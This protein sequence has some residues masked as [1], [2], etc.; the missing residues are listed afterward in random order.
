MS[1]RRIGRLAVVRETHPVGGRGAVDVVNEIVVIDSAGQQ[2]TVGR[3]IRLRLRP[4]LVAGRSCAGL[5]G[6]GP[7]RDAVGRDHPEGP[8]RDGRGHRRR[9]RGPAARGRSASRA[10]RRTARCGSAR[11]A[12]TGGG[13]TAGRTRV[14]SSGWST[15]PA[16]SAD[17]SGSSAPRPTASC[18]DG[19]V[20]FALL[21]DGRDSRLAARSG[22]DRGRARRR[23]HLRRGPGA[24][25]ATPSRWSVP[26]RSQS[27]R[28]CAS[29][30]ARAA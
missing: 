24:R 12:R 18:S 27:P 14:A 21:H 22:R 28:S 8:D 2:D 19:R 30:S 4:A 26:R 6:V 11:T 25:R 16:R 1:T 20:V 17:R 23:G 15:C 29:A 13:C 10:G 9:R 5:A 3:R 7:P